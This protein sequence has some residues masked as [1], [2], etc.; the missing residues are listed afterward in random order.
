MNIDE[1]Q[2]DIKEH[3]QTFGESFNAN[4]EVILPLLMLF[5]KIFEGITH[6]QEHAYKLSNSEADVLITTLVS[7]DDKLT[8]TP[9]RLQH[10][11]LFT[12]GGITKIL[13]KLEEKKL[14]VR[15]ED[16]YDKRSKLVQLT[17][18]GEDVTRK[19][20]AD[21]T[22][23]HDATLSSLTPKEKALLQTLVIKMIKNMD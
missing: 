5:Q 1:L 10:K 20:F 2:S 8:I 4:S 11:L 7:G 23:F 17:A 21:L 19:L 16:A 14:I 3:K 13:M 6:V 18:F 15:R 12:S 22:R 9:T